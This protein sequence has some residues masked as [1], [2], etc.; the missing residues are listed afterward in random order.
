MT[1]FTG[2]A[3]ALVTPF[4]KGNID[5]D[6][7]KDLIEWQIEEGIDAIV[8]CGTTGEASTLSDEEHIETVRFTVEQTQG[9]VPVIA[10]AGSNNTSHAIW[11]SQQLE[12]V[13]ADGLLLVTPYYNK[14]TQKGLVNHYKA[15]AD[16]VN[17]PCILYSVQSRTGVNITPAAVSEL[18]THPNIVGIKEASGN[19]SQVVEIAKY[20]SSNFALYSGNDDMIVPLLSMGGIG[21][22]S[23]VAN[24]IPKDT[25]EMIEAYLQNQSN[26]AREMQLHMKSLIDAMF[27]EV[28]PIPVKAALN[29]MGFVEKEYRMP[30]CEPENKTLYQIANELKSYGLL[31]NTI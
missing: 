8:S 14:C 31:S 30:L 7:L 27:I 13:G 5:F 21:A 2:A 4:K 10:G 19:I 16:S 29:I 18:C 20:V 17:L 11:M 12:K 15:I 24:I 9:R 3:V 23:T 26:K 22:I 6:A 1:L 28:N 25:H